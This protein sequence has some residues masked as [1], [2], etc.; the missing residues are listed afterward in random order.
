[1]TK[2]SL[3]CTIFAAL[4]LAGCALDMTVRARDNGQIYKGSAHPD[5]FGSGS[6]EMTVDGRTYTG[7]IQQNSV[8]GGLA[9]A[10]SGA[11][12]AGAAIPGH[13]TGGAILTSQDGHSMHCDLA[14]NGLNHGTA[15]CQDDQGRVYDATVGPH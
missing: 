8:T 2:S 11:G 15:L 7:T 6:I 14:G 13:N 12:I 5:G 9:V 1:M 4:I 10:A 3:L